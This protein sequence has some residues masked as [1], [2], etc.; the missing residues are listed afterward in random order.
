MTLDESLSQY[1]HAEVARSV[2]QDKT[3]LLLQTFEA[4]FARTSG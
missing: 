2:H 4:R 1:P 3:S